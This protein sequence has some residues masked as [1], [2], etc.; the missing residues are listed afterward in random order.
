MGESAGFRYR[1]AIAS[2]KS[3]RPEQ[4]TVNVGSKKGGKQKIRQQDDGTRNT[5]SHDG[6]PKL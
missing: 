5:I 2:F 1:F 3:L 4:Y 6:F